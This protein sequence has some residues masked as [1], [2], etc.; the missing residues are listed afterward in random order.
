MS[1][2]TPHIVGIIIISYTTIR[3]RCNTDDRFLRLPDKG[4]STAS[5]SEKNAV[6]IQS[7]GREWMS[8]YSNIMTMEKDRT[9]NYGMNIEPVESEPCPVCGGVS[10]DYLLEDTEGV[11]VGC[12]D[13]LKKIYC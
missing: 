1:L 2:T 11:F 6:I 7:K 4:R 8:N 13:C 12:D 5:A 3:G 10:W 9:A